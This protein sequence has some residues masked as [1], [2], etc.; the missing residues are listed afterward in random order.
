MDIF[1]AEGKM[2]YVGRDNPW[3]EYYCI[4]LSD[5]RVIGIGFDS[6]NWNGNM[7]DGIPEIK[8]PPRWE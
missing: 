5:G 1:E 7:D 3:A 6:E 8:C 2:S 4:E